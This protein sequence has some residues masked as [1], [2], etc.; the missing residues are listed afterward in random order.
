MNRRTGAALQQVLGTVGMVL[1]ALILGGVLVLLSENSPG[2]AYAAILRGA[3]GSPQKITEL[4]VKLIPILLLA[5]GVS[6]A[7][8]AQLWNIGAGGQFIMGSIVTRFMGP[9]RSR[10]ALCFRSSARSRPALSGRDLRVFSKTASTP[11][12]SSRP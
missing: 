6:I 3:F 11:T 12:R 9:C 5:F 8:K 10:C 1:I 4:F 7:Y 2:E